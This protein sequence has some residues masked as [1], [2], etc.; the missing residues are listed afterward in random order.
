MKDND[1][2]FVAVRDG[3]ILVKNSKG[4]LQWR[5]SEADPPSKGD[6]V[7]YSPPDGELD[8]GEVMNIY[9]K[10]CQKLGLAA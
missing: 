2:V 3:R 8:G 6:T 10:L 1:M 7:I 5:E 9:K 4:V